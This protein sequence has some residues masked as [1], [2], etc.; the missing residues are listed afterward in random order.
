[1]I[2]S[3][4]KIWSKRPALKQQTGAATVEFAFAMIALFVFF[5][6]YMQFVQIFIAHEQTTFAGFAA[7][8]THAVKGTGAAISTAVAVD[9]A[10]AVEFTSNELL[11][12]RDVPIPT[13]IDQF[14][15]GGQ[16]RFTV[17]HQSPLFKEPV[18]NDDNPVPY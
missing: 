9:G 17:K 2:C 12:S 3:I 14:L 1:V 18:F 4:K 10:A 8:R 11:M 6:I 13:G 16:G 15:T 5:A 7:A